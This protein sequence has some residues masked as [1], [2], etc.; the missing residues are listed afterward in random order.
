M[1]SYRLSRSAATDLES[2]AE[3]SIDRFGIDQ[4]RLYRDELKACFVRL[5]AS[6]TLGRRVEQ[7]ARNLRRFEHG[8]HIVFYTSNEGKRPINHTLPSR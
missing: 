7:I 6:P 3:F 5:A 4:A 8:S 1:A 2:I